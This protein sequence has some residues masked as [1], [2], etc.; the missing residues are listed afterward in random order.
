MRSLYVAMPSINAMSGAADMA[1]RARAASLLPHAARTAD[2]ATMQ[3]DVARMIEL[4]SGVR[5]SGLLG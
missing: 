5:I 2:K 3:T 4:R 1:A